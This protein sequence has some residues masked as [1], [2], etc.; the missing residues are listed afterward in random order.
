MVS[1]REREGGR[2]GRDG[3]HDVC[4]AEDEFDGSSIYSYSWEHT[5]VYH[6]PK[7]NSGKLVSCTRRAREQGDSEKDAQ[8]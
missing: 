7:R 5:R 4:A 1:G 6:Y 3:P 2:E 8:R